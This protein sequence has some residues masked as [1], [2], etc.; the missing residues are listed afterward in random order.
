MENLTQ[1]KDEIL[2]I[3][4]RFLNSDIHTISELTKALY[5][6]EKKVKSENK[7]PNKNSDLW[8][9]FHKNDTLATTISNI[10]IDLKGSGNNYAFIIDCMFIA[11]STN[12]LEI[13][14]S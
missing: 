5:V 11:I 10:E 6:V 2:L 8:F 7:A 14:Y 12:E 13:Y 9:R 4:K 3:F 1:Y